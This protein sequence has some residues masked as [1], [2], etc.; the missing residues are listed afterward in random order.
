MLFHAI[1]VKIRVAC[2][3]LLLIAAVAGC[4][5]KYTYTMGIE[6]EKS[7]RAKSD[8]AAYMVAF[9]RYILLKKF[10]GDLVEAGD[11][12]AAKYVPDHFTLFN[13]DGTDITQTV[14]FSNKELIEKAYTE[15]IRKT[16]NK[17][18][19]TNTITRSKQPGE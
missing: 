9:K 6:P 7:V 1:K 13:K 11:S 8:S 19:K 3:F 10:Y 5:N 4:N 2:F 17:W 15:M 14:N 18:K 12:S 16:P